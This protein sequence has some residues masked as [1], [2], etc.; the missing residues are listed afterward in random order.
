MT[1][2]LDPA[3]AFW[4]DHIVWLIIIIVHPRCLMRSVF[5]QVFRLS[6][7]ISHASVKMVIAYSLLDI[8]QRSLDRYLISSLRPSELT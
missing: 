4:A 2:D 6:V 3:R 7:G 1:S 5:S 8:K